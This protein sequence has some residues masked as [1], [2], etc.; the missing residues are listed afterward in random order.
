MAEGNEGILL[1]HRDAIVPFF[2]IFAS[3]CVDSIFKERVDNG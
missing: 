3:A 1:R 2:I